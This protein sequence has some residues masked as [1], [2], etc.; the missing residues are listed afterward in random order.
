MLLGIEPVYK[1]VPRGLTMSKKLPIPGELLAAASSPVLVY[2]FQLRGHQLS[3]SVLF[4]PDGAPGINSSRNGRGG[5]RTPRP[6]LLVDSV[7]VQSTLEPVQSLVK[8][9]M[10]KD[11]RPVPSGSFVLRWDNQVH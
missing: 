5:G 6:T 7:P 9:P 10:L 4:Q 8:I 3:F 2:A 1:L 11:G